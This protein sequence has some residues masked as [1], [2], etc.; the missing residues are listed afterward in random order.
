MI[1]KVLTLCQKNDISFDLMKHWYDG[2]DFKDVGAIYN[3]NSVM[4]AIRYKDFDSYWTETSAAEG[5]LDYIS[6]D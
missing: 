4:K 1:L 5:L 2:Y 6:K 3:P